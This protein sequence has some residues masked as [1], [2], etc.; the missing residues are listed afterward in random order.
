VVVPVAD[1]NTYPAYITTI[2]A[3][4]PIGGMRIAIAKAKADKLLS[5]ET[6]YWYR[7]SCLLGV[8]EQSEKD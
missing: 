8:C 3:T 2:P 6:E 1:I 4:A 7:I 5:R